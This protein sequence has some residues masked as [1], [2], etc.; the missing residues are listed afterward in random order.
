MSTV[1][2][3]IRGS[4]A[5]WLRVAVHGDSLPGPPGDPFRAGGTNRFVGILPR[6]LA[7]PQSMQGKPSY[8]GE[9]LA[10]KVC[11]GP[12]WRFSVP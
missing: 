10:A 8:G 9:V 3:L 1:K 12:S 11:G 4:A 2:C 7:S 6:H 5:S